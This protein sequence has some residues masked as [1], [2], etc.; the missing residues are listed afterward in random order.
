MAK[1][2]SRKE[3]LED[4]LDV[5]NSMR[6]RLLDTLIEELDDDFIEVGS[7]IRVEKYWNKVKNLEV[8]DTIISIKNKEY[9]SEES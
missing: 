2:N 6:S 8:L 4:Q 3:F 7:S 9:D 5:Y 1:Y